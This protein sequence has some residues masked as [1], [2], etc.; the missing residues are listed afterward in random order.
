MV[1]GF[2]KRVAYFITN[3]QVRLEYPWVSVLFFCAVFLILAIALWMRLA[4]P[5]TANIDGD[6]SGYLNPAL[7]FLGGAPLLPDR[8]RGLYYE[9]FLLL[10]MTAGR[11][12]NAIAFCQHLLG[13][14]GLFFMAIAFWEASGQGKSI[15]HMLIILGG[16]AIIAWNGQTIFMEHTVRPEGLAIFFAGTI[17]FLLQKLSSKPTVTDYAILVFLS[18]LMFLTQPKFILAGLLMMGCGAYLYLKPG[19][20]YLKRVKPVATCLTGCLLIWLFL[21]WRFT[22][23]DNSSSFLAKNFFYINCRLIRQSAGFEKHFT[24]TEKDAVC[25]A[26]NNINDKQIWP[27]LG[28]NADWMIYGPVGDTLESRYGRHVYEPVMLKSVIFCL[29]DFIG[30]IIKQGSFYYFNTLTSERIPKTYLTYRQQLQLSLNYMES[31]SDGVPQWKVNYEKGVR[32]ILNGDEKFELY[33]NLATYLLWRVE[34]FLSTI[35]A[36][37]AAIYAIYTLY[38]RR[39]DMIAFL[40]TAHFLVF[41]TIA[42]VHTIDIERYSFAVFPLFAIYIVLML[43]RLADWAINVSVKKLNLV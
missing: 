14:T 8:D 35:L 5:A 30:K 18:A 43:M 23:S 41:V 39:P 1:P 6:V 34:M 13:F 42:M 10:F 9:L 24:N 20:H 22:Q 15:I 28:Y 12:I 21:G 36:V 31:I 37:I 32:E 29:P 33:H 4:L 27:L 26:V 25:F 11:G 19:P 7:D 2:F 38:K 16:L 3:P 17:F 40:F